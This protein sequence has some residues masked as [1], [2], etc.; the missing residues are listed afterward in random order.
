MVSFVPDEDKVDRQLTQDEAYVGGLLFR[1]LNVM[2]T[3]THDISEFE[4]PILDSFAPGC[5]K[6]SVGAGL[7]PCLALLNHGCEPSFMRCNKGN[8]V[9]CVASKTIKKGQ[10]ICE[11][12]GLMYTAKEL[13]ERQKILLDHYK[14]SCACG[15]CTE[16]WPSLFSMKEELK[17]DSDKRLARFLG[18]S[19]IFF[20]LFVLE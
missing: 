15:P 11:N 3:N 18:N 9:I 8:V 5:V 6:V 13:K 12:Y 14:F 20:I 1:L 2:P 4:T 17:A 16:N 10:E 19:T 7:Y